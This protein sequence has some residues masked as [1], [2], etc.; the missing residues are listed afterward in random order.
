[1]YRN[2]SISIIMPCYNEEE[3]LPFVLEKIPEW[4]DEVIIVDNNS[5]DLTARIGSEKGARVFR[6]EKQGYGHAYFKGFAEAKGDIFITLDGDG[7]YPLENCAHLVDSLIDTPL[8]FI[9][10][11]RFP[12]QNPENMDPVSKL[13][14]WV[15]T[16]MTGILFNYGLKDSQSGMWVFRAETLPKLQLKSKGM[17]F[18]EEIKVEAIRRGLRFKEVHIPYYERYGTKKIKKFEDGIK[19]LVYLFRLRLRK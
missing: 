2:F 16:L 9:S 10:A 8:D 6:E 14:N 1:M 13:G 11:C 12:L 4:V 5:T 7:T 19:N 18:S 3:G 15:L 17:A